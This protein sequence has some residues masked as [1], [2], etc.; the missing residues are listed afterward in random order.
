MYSKEK[1]LR[2]PS[3]SNKMQLQTAE[4]NLSNEFI[5]SYESS[6]INNFASTNDSVYTKP[7][8]LQSNSQQQFTWIV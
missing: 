5:Q 1:Y 7:D 6:L 2:S 4:S 3:E 8:E